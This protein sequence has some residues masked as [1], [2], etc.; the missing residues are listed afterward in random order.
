MFFPDP[1][2]SIMQVISLKAEEEMVMEQ[3]KYRKNVK[4]QGE[5]EKKI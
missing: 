4:G 2:F 3:E 5:K 1:E